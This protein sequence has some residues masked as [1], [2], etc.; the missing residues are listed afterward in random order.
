[1]FTRIDLVCSYEV[2]VSAFCFALCTTLFISAYIQSNVGQLSMLVGLIL[3]GGLITVS[4]YP[5]GLYFSI[6]L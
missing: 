6:V 1:M 4:C 5:V 2:V 3:G